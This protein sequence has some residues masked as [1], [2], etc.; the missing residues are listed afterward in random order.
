MSWWYCQAISLSDSV[1]R[2][3]L[4]S[5]S[6]GWFSSFACI[7]CFSSPSVVVVVSWHL[8]SSEGWGRAEKRGGRSSADLCDCTPIQQQQC[9]MLAKLYMPG[10]QFENFSSWHEPWIITAYA[11]VCHTKALWI[12]SKS[13]KQ[14]WLESKLDFLFIV[15]VAFLKFVKLSITDK[16]HSLIWSTHCVVP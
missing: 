13:R 9:Y 3:F 7:L 10:T 15:F 6:C 16:Q 14:F 4:F 1:C 2:V 11:H 12:Y 8:Y 5:Y